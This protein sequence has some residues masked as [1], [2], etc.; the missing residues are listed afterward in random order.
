MNLWNMEFEK[1]MSIL[2]RFLR[3]STQA[4]QLE[5]EVLTS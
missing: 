1:N 4:F 2:A 5:T 3:D